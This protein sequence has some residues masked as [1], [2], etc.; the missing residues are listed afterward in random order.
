[1]KKKAVKSNNTSNN[2]KS[3]KIFNIIIRNDNLYFLDYSVNLIWDTNT[4]VV[5]IIN[6][7][8]NMFFSTIDNIIN[9]MNQDK[10]QLI[11]L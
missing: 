3:A 4:D 7:K 5:G 6:N 10:K 1:M 11:L 8:K 2:Y 9:E